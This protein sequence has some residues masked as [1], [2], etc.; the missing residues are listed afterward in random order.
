MQS[1]EEIDIP[2]TGMKID[3]DLYK[4][5]KD[6]IFKDKQSYNILYSMVEQ[7]NFIDAEKYFKEKYLNKTYS[8]DKLR[9]SLGLNV[10]IDIK[11]LLL[12]LFGFISKIKNKEEILEEEFNKLDDKFKPDENIFYE[13]KHIFEEY[14]TNKEFRDIIDSKKISQLSTHPMGG[15]FNNLPD[16]L[17]WGIPQYIRDNV[18]I[19]KFIDA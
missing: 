17:K 5:F 14:I 19:E 9:A 10:N 12:Y 6:D 4:S 7:Q 8:L 18:K 2:Q 11:D 16:D 1:T 15:L 13:A 3:R